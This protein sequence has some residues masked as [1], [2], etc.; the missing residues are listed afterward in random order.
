MNLFIIV[1]YLFIISHY[2]NSDHNFFLYPP[3]SG[4]TP[5][6]PHANHLHHRG[7]EVM[8]GIERGI[9]CRKVF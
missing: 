9:E 3:S 8:R 1:L 7:D 2:I 6:T 5:R 4:Y